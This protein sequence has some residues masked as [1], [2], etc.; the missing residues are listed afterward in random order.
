MEQH[1]QPQLQLRRHLRQGVERVLP[2]VVAVVAVALGKAHHVQHLRP[3]HADDL[4]VRPQGLRRTGGGQKSFQFGPDPL[5]GDQGQ[6]G[7]VGPEAPVCLLLHR[8]AQ[9]RG[10]PHPPEDPQRVLPEPPVRLPHAPQ[11]PGVQ[12]RPAAQGVRQ[13]TPEVQSHGVDGEV[14]AA[15]V[16]LQRVG[17]G[18]GLGT[19]V[20]PV[21]PVPAEGSYLHHSAGG[22]DGDG[23]VGQA[24]GHGPVPED[25]EDPLRH[26]GGGHVPV[27]GRPAQEAVPHAAA[28]APSPKARPLQGRQHLR[29][30]FRDLYHVRTASLSLRL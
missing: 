21:G 15:Q 29:R 4:W 26:R 5:R 11:Q 19:P 2:H 25:G 24:R 8:K 17:E 10:E 9:G 6:Q 23:A 12:V 18:H 30:V 27:L 1:G 22:P 14:P 13:F 28:H 7:P 3:E 20:V 16:L